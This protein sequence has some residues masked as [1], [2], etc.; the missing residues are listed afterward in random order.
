MTLE[1]EG[2]LMVRIEK[3]LPSKSFFFQNP[4]KNA[5]T[6]QQFEVKDGREMPW[7]TGN[8]YSLKKYL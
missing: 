5:I 2:L 7:K 8:I 1:L 3:Y 6:G 4:R